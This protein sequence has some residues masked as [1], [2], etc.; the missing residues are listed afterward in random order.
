MF[1]AILTLKV[2]RATIIRFM[3]RKFGVCFEQST[4]II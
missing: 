3:M 4:V 2:G 1:A